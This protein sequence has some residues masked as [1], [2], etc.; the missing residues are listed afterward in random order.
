MSGMKIGQIELTGH[1]ALAPMAGVADRAF[2]RICR[3]WGAAFTVSEM[4]SS[5]GLSFGDRKSGELLELDD[6]ERPSAVQ[7]FGN[8][9]DTMARAATLAMAANPDWIDINMGCPAPKIAGNGCGSALLRDPDLCGRLVAAVKAA[10]GCPVTAKIRLGYSQKTVNAVEVA[11]ACEAGGAA[12]VTVHG[13]TREQMYAPPVDVGGIRAVKQALHIPVIANG[14]VTDAASAAAMLEQTGCDLLMVGRGA[15]GAPWVFAQI[16]AYLGEGRILPDPP[17]AVRMATLYRQAKT[18]AGWK[19]ERVALR[20]ARKHA[21]WYMHGWRG[22]AAMRA[23][24]SE[25]ET[26]DDLAALCEQVIR[27]AEAAGECK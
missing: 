19:G 3:G 16:E 25:L 15:L 23:R 1:A 20:E 12:A 2:R 27:A 8:E 26:L 17:M 14:D 4:V 7:L 9:P 21:A 11:Q 5:K 24:A 10:A 6:E 18:A 22:A 13:R